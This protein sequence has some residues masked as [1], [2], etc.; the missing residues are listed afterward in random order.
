MRKVFALILAF[1][2]LAQSGYTA[3]Q[4]AKGEPAGTEAAG[5]ID[6]LI[7]VNNGAQD[8]LLNNYRNNLSV[9]YASAS[10][11]AVLPGE[12]AIPNAAISVVRYRETTTNTTVS[13]ADI[14]TGAEATST[15]YYVYATADTDVTGMVFKISASSTAPSGMTYYRKIGYFYNDASGNIVNIGNIKDASVPNIMSVTGTSDISTS[16]TSFTAMTD[17]SVRFVSNGR[18]VKVFY[19]GPMLTSPSNGYHYL[20]VAIDGVTK[21]VEGSSS[22]NHTE[23]GDGNNSVPYMYEE[24]LSAGAH[25]VEMQWKAGAGTLY[26]NGATFN[27]KLIVEEA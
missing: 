14:D 19:T 5:T 15:Q 25:T 22:N 23:H 9:I 20:T 13:W 8:R 18:P 24:T 7:R 26:Q 4:W 16:S 11:L 2:L 17:M 10:T 12:V 1:G 6:N 3:D 27:R 21:T